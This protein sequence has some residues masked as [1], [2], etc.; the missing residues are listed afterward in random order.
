MKRLVQGESGSRD[1]VV[2]ITS[3][4]VDVK[5]C[6]KKDKDSTR[7]ELD[8]K[9]QFDV[10][11]SEV[12]R[13]AALWVNKDMQNRMRTDRCNEKQLEKLEAEVISVSEF[14]TPKERAPRDPFVAAKNAF[15]KLSEEDRK[16]LISQYASES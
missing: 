12:Y 16:A 15:A 9:Y 11:E 4:V 10:E 8:F 3:K 13:L 1:V 5:H 14:Y 2:D 7:Y 6:W